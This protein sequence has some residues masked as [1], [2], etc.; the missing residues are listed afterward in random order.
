[1]AEFVND[2]FTDS[3]GTNLENHTGETGADWSVHPASSGG[4]LEIWSN[5]VRESNGTAFWP[6]YIASGTP[7][8]AD[9]DVEASVKVGD[10]DAP[11]GRIRIAGRMDSTDDTHY[12]ILWRQDNQEFL[13]IREVSGSQTTLDTFAMTGDDAV[14]TVKLEMRGD[15]IKGYIDGVEQLTATDSGITAAGTAGLIA[16]NLDRSRVARWIVSCEDFSATDAPTGASSL[17]ILTAPLR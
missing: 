1:M 4:P 9:Y 16:T 12:S 11:G 3:D 13:M 5:D 8:S 15:A 10:S 2:T 6:T 7:A 17:P 14:H